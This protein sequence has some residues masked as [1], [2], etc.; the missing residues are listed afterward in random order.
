MIFYTTF[1]LSYLLWNW[2]IVFRFFQGDRR[3][4]GHILT[5][6]SLVYYMLGIS[7]DIRYNHMPEFLV[8]DVVGMV[9]LVLMII[10]KHI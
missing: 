6:I 4:I 2:S 5:V 3:D 7:V 8:V 10:K 1:I 9:S